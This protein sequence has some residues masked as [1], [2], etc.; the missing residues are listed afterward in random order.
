[1]IN[2]RLEFYASNFFSKRR[3]DVYDSFNNKVYTLKNKNNLFINVLNFL[4]LF[5]LPNSYHIYEKDG[6]SLKYVRKNRTIRWVQAIETKEVDIIE[7]STISSGRIFTY[8]EFRLLSEDSLSMKIYL[9]NNQIGYLKRLDTKESFKEIKD[10]FDLVL[11][12][13]NQSIPNITLVFF[14]EV[15]YSR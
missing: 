3:V 2:Y 15:Y 4:L 5:K 8:G 12:T 11:F 14:N 10:I 7:A 1:M 9:E 13:E 6:M